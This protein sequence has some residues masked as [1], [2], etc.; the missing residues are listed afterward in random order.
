MPPQIALPSRPSKIVCV[1]RNYADHAKELGN[2]VPKEPLIFLKPPSSLISDGDPI[3]YP[4][5]SQRVDFEGELGIVIGQRSRN[6][7]QARA[8]DCIAGYTIINDVTARDLQ[9]KDGQWTRGKGFDTFCPVA[10]WYVPRLAVD[11]DSLEIRTTVNNDEKQHG[12]VREM[13]FAPD[14]IIA[15]VTQFMT[16]EPGDLIA[17][18]TPPGVGP[19][20][21]GDTVRIEISGL[22]TLQN[23]VVQG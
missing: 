15:F 11:F 10:P 4:P 8:L 1:G 14:A 22:G 17:T 19:L 9:K 6:V 13:I 18:G 5:I 2:E 16:L 12:S 21:P 3:I 20:Q 23:P 7:D